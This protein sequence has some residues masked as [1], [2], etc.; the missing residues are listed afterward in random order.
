MPWRRTCWARSSE[1]GGGADCQSLVERHQ[2]M[3]QPGRIGLRIVEAEMPAAALGPQQR[4]R[5]DQGG[6]GGHVEEGA[7]DPFGC[8]FELCDQPKGL[9]E[10]GVV[11]L[12]PDE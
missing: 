2:R 11:A 3:V 9:T 6:R 10:P 5:R 12:D 1:S 7:G 8:T 4:R